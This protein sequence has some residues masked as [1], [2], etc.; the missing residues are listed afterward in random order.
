MIR[1]EFKALGRNYQV[2]PNFQ[3]L[4]QGAR[5]LKVTSFRSCTQFL[6]CFP[7]TDS[8]TTIATTPVLET[9]TT[10]ENN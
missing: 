10:T 5:E 7:T 2:L 1:Q 9:Y 6:L 3:D 8:I 4:L